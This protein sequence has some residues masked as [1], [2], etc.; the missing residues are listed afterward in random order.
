MKII[1]KGKEFEFQGYTEPR[2]G[3]Y[4]IT[5][6]GI[7]TKAEYNIG[8]RLAVVRPVEVFHE[9]G[10]I[11]FKEIGRAETAQGEIWCIVLGSGRIQCL[12]VDSNISYPIM[13]LEP[14]SIV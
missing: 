1:Y 12:S 14:V 13:V 2:A 10:G 11:R 5:S 8:T 9:F 3:D 4:Y 7:V 6:S